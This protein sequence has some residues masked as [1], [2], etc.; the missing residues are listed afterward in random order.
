MS[1]ESAREGLYEAQNR[2]WKLQTAQR[3]TV[4][5]SPTFCA[6]RD[7]YVE[8]VAAVGFLR[9]RC[10]KE[11]RAFGEEETCILRL[12]LGRLHP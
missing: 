4:R 11:C 1:V 10:N 8:C 6:S 3:R 2:G 7:A 9:L 12:S 5:K